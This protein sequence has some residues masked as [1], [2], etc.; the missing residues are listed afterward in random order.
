MLCWF[1]CFQNL[2]SANLV[3]FCFWQYL[4]TLVVI[5]LP[6]VCCFC[7]LLISCA[8]CLLPLAVSFTRPFRLLCV[9]APLAWISGT[10]CA[11]PTAHAHHLQGIH[12]L[13]ESRFSEF[14]F[15]NLLFSQQPPESVTCLFC[16]C[17]ILAMSR[18]RNDGYLWWYHSM[19]GQLLYM[20]AQNSFTLLVKGTYFSVKKNTS[21]NT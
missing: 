17:Q 20:P 5:S 14:L 15:Q 10:C 12:D 9:M 8:I 19:Q 21:S 6:S 16:L 4:K 2:A 1:L 18:V 13:V 3:L 11:L 7:F